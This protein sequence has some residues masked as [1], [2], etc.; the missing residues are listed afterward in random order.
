M[1]SRSHIDSSVKRSG[2][3]SLRVFYPAGQIGPENSGVSAPFALPKAREYYVKQWIRFSPDFSWG[4]TQYAGKIGIGLAGGA[5]CSGG[6]VCD[7]YNGFTSRFTWRSG[8]K[9]A[10]YFYHMGKTG[11]YGDYLDLSINGSTVH[12]PRGQWVEIMQRVKVNTVTNGNANP[13]GEIQAWYSG[14]SAGTVKGLRFVRNSDLVD[15]AYFSSFFGG[16]TTDFAPA[17]DSSIWHDDVQVSTAP[18]R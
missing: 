17:N 12:Y 9:V 3:K 11:R 18:T 8:G 15:R 7:G 5:S 4:T 2:A 14:T 10:L 13:D 16:S 6:Q 1:S